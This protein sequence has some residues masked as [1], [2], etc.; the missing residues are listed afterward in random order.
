MIG[1]VHVDVFHIFQPI[2]KYLYP[3]F[4]YPLATIMKLVKA[5]ALL[6]VPLLLSS[7]LA[8]MPVA[9]ASKPITI[10]GT[11]VSVLTDYEYGFRLAGNN[12][13]YS[14]DRT[15]AYYGDLAG[16][17]VG[18]ASNVVHDFVDWTHFSFAESHNIQ[19]FA[20]ATVGDKTG[21]LTLLFDGK[22]IVGSNGAYGYT[23]HVTI[24]SGTGGLANLHGQG[25]AWSAPTD[26]Y[27][28]YQLQVHFDP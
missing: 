5:L 8:T 28:F 16:D 18:T 10:S 4:K 3:S 25:T 7:F 17:F 13:F 24:L 21:G 15:G 22:V 9:Y 1:L 2:L 6:L 23:A 14:E 11:L 27:E 12:L 20:S 26:I 19:T